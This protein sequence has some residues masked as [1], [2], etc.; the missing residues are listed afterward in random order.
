VKF[1]DELESEI[2]IVPLEGLILMKLIAS[3]EPESRHF[4]KNTKAVL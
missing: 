2:E 4:P 1:E 3:S